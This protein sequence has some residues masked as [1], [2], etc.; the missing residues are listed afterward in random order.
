MR[1]LLQ[2]ASGQICKRRVEGATVGSCTFYLSKMQEATQE[3]GKETVRTMAEWEWD[4]LWK[5]AAKK[6][7][8]QHKL[9]KAAW[10]RQKQSIRELVDLV[11]ELR[12]E[13]EGRGNE[14]G[15]GI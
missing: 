1:I 13:L 8:R 3:S 10:E 15:E 7:R 11:D 14:D 6:H 4:A 9:Y 5:R 12:A 2:E